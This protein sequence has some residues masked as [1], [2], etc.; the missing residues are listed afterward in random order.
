MYRDLSVKIPDLK[1]EI[2]KKNKREQLMFIMNMEVFTW[3]R[4]TD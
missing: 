2:S 3:Q 4:H 1:K